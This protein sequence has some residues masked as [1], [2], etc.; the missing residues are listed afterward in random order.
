MIPA[1]TAL[2]RA[3][4]GRLRIGSIS[5]CTA[6]L[7]RCLSKR[8]I[9]K[10]TSKAHR[11]TRNILVSST[12]MTRHGLRLG[13]FDL[14]RF[15]WASRMYRST[16][17]LIQRQGWPGQPRFCRA[18][19]RTLRPLAARMVTEPET[20]ERQEPAEGHRAANHRVLDGRFAGRRLDQ[21]LGAST[22]VGT[23]EASTHLPYEPKCPKR[24][25]PPSR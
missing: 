18:P 9:P 22:C 21:N 23:L 19:G 8:S 20:H 1:S 7:A 13:P 4:T 14:S 17:T 3:Q 6:A 2:S 15:I 12:V 24:S 25:R 11:V 5:A 16:R 10:S